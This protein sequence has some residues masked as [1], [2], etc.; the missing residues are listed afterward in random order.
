M[1][2]VELI[3]FKLIGVKYELIN[4]KSNNT[5]DINIHTPKLNDDNL[6]KVLT[7]VAD[8]TIN[9]AGVLKNEDSYRVINIVIHGLFKIKDNDKSIVELETIFREEVGNLLIPYLRTLVSQLTSF[10]STTQHLLLPL[11]ELE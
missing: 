10:D 6:N 9:D 3:N 2:N 4:G 7:G 11:I 1:K 8:I 5:I